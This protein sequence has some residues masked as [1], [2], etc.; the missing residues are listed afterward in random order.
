[1]ATPIDGLIWSSIRN[2][3]DRLCRFC[4]LKEIIQA[5]SETTRP[6]TAL[7]HHDSVNHKR[8]Y[9]M[10]WTFMMFTGLAIVFAQLGAYSILVA[11][12]AGGLKLALLVIA[13]FVI[14]LLWRKVFQKNT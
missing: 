14:V 2:D 12:L 5:V 11:V 3:D 9:S 13:G 6:V 8:R 4:W 1:M 7:P 10:F